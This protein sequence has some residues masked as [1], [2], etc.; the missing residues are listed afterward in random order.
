MNFVPNYH[1]FSVPFNFQRKLFTNHCLS[2]GPIHFLLKIIDGPSNCHISPTSL[3]P[4][5]KGM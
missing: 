2:I 3:S 1:L 5:K 4:M